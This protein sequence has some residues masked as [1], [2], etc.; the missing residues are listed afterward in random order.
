MVTEDKKGEDSHFVWC[1][2]YSHYL[3]LLKD[4]V[5]GQ[6]VET[7]HQNSDGGSPCDVECQSHIP[8]VAPAI[9]LTVLQ[10]P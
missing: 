10:V 2:L 7:V 1:V 6:D 4:L 9:L 3:P 5:G 8:A